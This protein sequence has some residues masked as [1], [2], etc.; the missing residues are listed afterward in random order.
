[1]ALV[2]PFA[3]ET[4]RGF[5]GFFVVWTFFT[6]IL[7]EG[8]DFSAHHFVPDRRFTLIFREACFLTL[9]LKGLATALLFSIY[10]L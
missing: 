10:S 2:R 8:G 4:E 6:L 3:G 1:V 5:F 7:H 9:I